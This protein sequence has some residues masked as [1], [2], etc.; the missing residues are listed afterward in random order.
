MSMIESTSPVGLVLAEGQSIWFDNIRRSLIASGE[1]ERMVREDGLRGVTS[2]PAIF[3]KAIAGSSD[4]T[5]A[6]AD[7]RGGGLGAEEIYE[8]LAIRDIQDAADIL[9]PVHEESGRRD[10]HVSLEVSPRLAH[11]ADATVAAAERLWR[12]VDRPNLMIKVPATDAGMEAVERLIAIGI[13]VN[14]TLLFATAAY[15]RVADAYMTG[16]ERLIAFGGDPARVAS[17]ASF[18]VSRIDSAV[19]AA[20]ADIGTPEARA[21]MGTTAIANAKVTYRRFGELFRGARWE[22]LAARGAGVQRLLWAS[23]GT[24][25]PAQPDVVYV[26]SLIGPETVDTIP[27]A[28]YDAFRDHGQVRRTVDTDLEA[29]DAAL[30]GVAGL[31][32]ELDAI[33]GRLLD[34]GLRLF[35]DAYATLLDAVA[36][37][38]ASPSYGASLPDAVRAGVEEELELWRAE[39]R[40]ARLWARDASVWTGAD[41]GR[42]LGWL[43]VVEDQLAHADFLEMIRRRAHEAGFRHTVLLGMGGSSLCPEMLART[44]GPQAGFPELH[45]LDSTDPAQIAALESRI[46]LEMTLFIVSSKS[47]AT[48]EPNVFRAYFFDRVRRALG[49]AEAGRRFIAI[50]DPGSDMEAAALADGFRHIAHG[51]PAIGGRYSALSNFGMIPG[52][53]MGVDMHALLDR[54]ERMAESCRA[55]VPAGENPGL[56]L[57]L[58]LGVSALHG[59][60]KLTLVAS[61]RIAALGAWLEQ[62]LAESTGKHGTG[63]V[64]VDREPL[65]DPSVYGPDRLF[66][67][68][69]LEGGAD[70]AQDAAV[71]ALEAAGHP[72]LRISL[73]DLYDLG[74]EIFRWEFAT[75]VAGSVLAINPFDQ[76]D[77]EASKVAT[78]RI[79]AAYAESGALPAESPIFDDGR[80]ALF[81]GADNAA[82]LGEHDD[83]AGYLRAHLGR[84]GEGDY[85]ALIAYVE[86]TEEHEDELTAMRTAIRDTTGAATCVGFGPRFL[87]STGQ[88]YKGGPNTGVFLQIT[89]D[90]AADLAIPGERFTF[91]VVKAAQARGDLEVLDERGR[92]ALRVHLRGD[93]RAGLAALRAHI[94]DSLR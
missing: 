78:R 14:V 39:G 66:A 50:T 41:E 40:V 25:N 87:H 28:T 16:L 45:V 68:L 15:E 6:I 51:V 82:A 44:W 4:Y 55:S 5:A 7:L 36:R 49:E 81:A 70:P 65:G 12:A 10:G 38:A 31:G 57:G 79:T 54:A 85:A 47:G 30:A 48:L 93:V 74:S 62:L 83:L 76:P 69:R 37:T 46:D 29:A 92:R 75:A 18:F 91:G 59:R 53:I 58:A 94:D 9:A 3:E 43:G 35:E 89:C 8:L 61:P 22:A 86:R 34:A 42:W 90:D 84:I 27:P 1:L 24:K 11:D 67:Y 23:T 60:D 21:L 71:D 63:I 20:L 88:A 32:I 80:V 77:V 52:G 72:V 26:E 13:N 64:P 33:T 2:N 56:L 19:D 73:T 17:V